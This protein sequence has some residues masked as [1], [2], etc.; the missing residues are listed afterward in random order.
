MGKGKNHVKTPTA[1]AGKSGGNKGEFTLKRVKGE[2][3]YRDAKSAS[4]VKMLNGGKAVRDRD[5]KITQSAAFQ[6]TEKEMGN[7]MGRVQPDRRWFGN[8]RV[9][10]QNA[11]DHFRTSLSAQVANPYSVLLRR[12][13]LPMGLLE[14]EGKGQEGKRVHIVETEPF[15]GTFGPKA[16]RKR[17]RLEV[18]SL[19]EL[20]K[21]VA[22]A[23]AEKEANPD[24]YIEQPASFHPV[25]SL[26]SEPIY[27]KGTSRRIWGE[28]YKVLDSSDVVIHVLD[29]RDPMG[30]RCKPVVEF[31]K[32]EKAHKQLIYVLNKVDLV[33]TWVTARWVK[34]LSLQAPTIAFHASINNSFG[35]GSLIQLLRQFSVLHSDKKQISVGLI[36]YPNVGK[37]SIINTLKKKKVCTVAP[38]PGE[39]K[40]WQ[41]ITLMKRIYLIDCPG[42]VPISAKDSETDT[43]LKGVV[44][45]ENLQTPAE[46]IPGLLKRVRPAY[47]ERTYGLEPREGGWE[48]EEGATVLLST[49][50]KRM[51]K[52]LKGGEPDQE[53]I[54]KIML[55]DWIRGKIPY[56]AM[57]PD[58]NAGQ[59]DAGKEVEGE[60]TVEEKAVQEELAAREAELAK[61]LGERKVKGVEQPL[62]NIITMSKFIGDDNRRIADDESDEEMVPG[63]GYDKSDDEDDVEAAEA[64]DEMAWDDLFPKAGSSSKPVMAGDESDDGGLDGDLG[65]DDELELED[66]AEKDDMEDEEDDEEE[67]VEEEEAVPVASAKAKGKRA[68][69][70]DL[71]ETDGKRPAK[72][73]RMTTNKQKSTNYYTTA[74]VKNRNRE[75]KVPKINST[76]GERPKAAKEGK[77][78]M[79]RS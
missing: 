12:N 46:H 33:P 57:P 9:I 17:P 14:E 27:A 65:D 72:A 67:E 1:S 44:R 51:G 19:E 4:R 13:K 37:S 10:S 66:D 26:M 25:R 23:H 52:L 32:K 43:V 24:A 45:V 74:N 79:R 73:P 11:L 62:R 28:L 22:D 41:Y 56:F 34:H 8:T 60:L 35:K 55:N 63:E 18:G 30:T 61:T 77:I 31:L 59:P 64:E 39:T 75:R 3:F 16:Q 54:A 78:R 68:A 58:K 50:A 71:D 47:I 7:E 40:V 76:K 42:I 49:I 38:I 48:G 70:A 15:S 53:S 29:A 20:G 36:G 69:V 6:K 21:D 2:N 5:G